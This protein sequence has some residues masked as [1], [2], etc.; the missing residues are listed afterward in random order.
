V[1]EVNLFGGEIFNADHI[2]LDITDE[3]YKQI[4]KQ[5]SSIEK[6]EVSTGIFT[7][8]AERYW[9]QKTAQGSMTIETLATGEVQIKKVIAKPFFIG[10]NFA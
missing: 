4:E 3:E 7:W 6:K 10:L 5:P 1:Y 9:T 2:W 8:H